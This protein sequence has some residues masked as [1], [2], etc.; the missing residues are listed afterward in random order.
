MIVQL[1]VKVA[2]IKATPKSVNQIDFCGHSF[3]QSIVHI[4]Y[5]L[6]IVV[7]FN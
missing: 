4:C 7:F 2:S 5:D 3:H 6:S 1:C